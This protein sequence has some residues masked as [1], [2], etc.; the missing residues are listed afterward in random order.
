MSQILSQ[1]QFCQIN[2]A[3]KHAHRQKNISSK[4]WWIIRERD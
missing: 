4:I 3:M 2:Y 1:T